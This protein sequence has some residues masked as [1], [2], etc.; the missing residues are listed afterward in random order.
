MIAFSTCWNS[1]RHSD[2]EAMIREIVDL[3]F[4]TIELSHGMNISLFPGIQKALEEKQF[5][6]AGLH[7]FCPSPIEVMI[8]APDCYEFTSHRKHE[9]ERALALTIKTI[10]FAEQ[11][12][13][14]Y[15]VLHLGSVAMRNTTRQLTQMVHDGKLNDREYVA[16]KHKFIKKREKAGPHYVARAKEALEPIIEHAEKKKVRLGIES[17][18]RF[19]DVPTERELAQLMEDIKSPY[20]GYWHD[21]GHVQ[22]KANLDLLDHREWLGRMQ[23][24]LVGCHLHD[25]EWPARDHRVPLAGSINYDE[26]MPLIPV[27]KPLVWELSPSRR[28]ADIKRA[29]P[30]WI[31][32]YGT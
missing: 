19:E 25:V 31:E 14:S 23:S 30:L 10:D 13:G 6:V 7:N 3:G 29:L 17:R 18:S 24:R 11:F 20:V 2:G 27:D 9:R 8:D 32:R 12:G 26:L 21:F 22:L 5:T 16:L 4:D 15:V 1:S 28:S